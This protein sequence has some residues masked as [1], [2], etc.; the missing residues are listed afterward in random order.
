MHSISN[1]ISEACKIGFELTKKEGA[2]NGVQNAVLA[3]EDSG[4]FNAG[5]GSVL[6]LTGKIEMDAA[7]MDGKNLTSGA[8]GAVRNVKN[9]IL[10][11][12][13]VLEE[14][15][16]SLIV[17]SKAEKIAERFGLKTNLV[18]TE[19]RQQQWEQ[20]RKNPTKYLKKN[21][22]YASDTVG[23][24]AIDSQGNTASA[25]STG[26][27]W[28]KLD[29]RVGDSA[30]VG[31]GFYAENG[32]GGV[33]ATGTGEAIM[34]LAL[35]KLVHEFM[36]LGK[37]AI[38]ACVYAIRS[39]TD[40]K[41]ANTAGIIA[42]DAFGNFGY[43]LNTKTMLIANFSDNMGRPVAKVLRGNIPLH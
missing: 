30:I 32:V 19:K 34:S 3:M 11:A 27:L 21:Q 42:L 7:I 38:D 35:S 15:D 18:P 10:L 31:A 4:L 13:K 12:R 14:T 40:K 23:A 1:A 43:A 5:I 16:H 6:T 41:G 29:G 39:I 36:V 26:G 22:T 25:V 28:L 9:P 24:V 2:L 20:I 37:S 17:G 8:V 33:A